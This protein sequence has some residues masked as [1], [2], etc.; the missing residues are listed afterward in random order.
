M[1]FNIQRFSLHDGPGIRTTVFFKGCPLDCCWCQ[2]P[3]GKSSEIDLLCSNNKCLACGM[4]I[5]QCP[6]KAVSIGESGP[7][8]DRNRCTVC[9]NCAAVCPAEAIKAVGRVITVPELVNEL[10]KDRISFEESGGGVTVS[11]GEPLLQPDFLIA[12]LK[13]LKYKNIHTAVETSGCAPWPVIEAVSDWA[14]LFLYDLKLIDNAKSRKYVGMSGSLMLNNLQKLLE[15]DSNVI[16]RMP[17]IPSVNDDESSLKLAADFLNQCAVT[18]LEL[19]PYHNFGIAKYA[20]LDLE[21][22]LSQIKAPSA[23]Q[24]SALAEKIEKYGISIINGVD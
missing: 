20:F 11:G 12:L 15:K 5:E 7:L 10:L 21:Y 14:A 17:V 22:N 6:E 3:E 1:I 13:A 19:I 2:N 18:Q 9:L 16:I 8:I 24:I 23:Q 4:C